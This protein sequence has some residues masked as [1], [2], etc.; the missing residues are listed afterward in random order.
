MRRAVNA[1]Q[2][3]RTAS[4]D[5][6]ATVNPYATSAKSAEATTPVVDVELGNVDES[7][8]DIAMIDS[9]LESYDAATIQRNEALDDR[10]RGEQRRSR[11]VP[12]HRLRQM[13]A[14]RA[15]LPVF[16]MKDVLTLFCFDWGE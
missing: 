14:S 7:L 5:T 13:S 6:P 16:S 8:L 11:Q 4:G 9:A 1:V 10:F 2:E 12:S 3:E 15:K